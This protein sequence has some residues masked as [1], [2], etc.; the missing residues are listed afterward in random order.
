MLAVAALLH[1]LLAGIGC[2]K[3]CY[4]ARSHAIAF[5]VTQRTC[6]VYVFLVYAAILRYCLA[7]AVVP[8]DCMS[9]VPACCLLQPA[10]LACAVYVPAAKPVALCM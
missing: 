7:T 5:Y 9:A 1:V 3:V 4:A 6:M 10:A 2:R 8:T